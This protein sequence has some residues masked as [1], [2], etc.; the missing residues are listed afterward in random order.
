MESLWKLYYML[1]RLCKT[2]EVS[3]AICFLLSQDASFIAS[4]DLPLDGDYMSISAGGLREHPN[5]AGTD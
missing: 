3:N 1:R 5:F 4:T 2:S